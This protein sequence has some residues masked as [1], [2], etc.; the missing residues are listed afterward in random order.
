MPSPMPGDPSAMPPVSS[1]GGDEA[2]GE[3][4]E[5]EDEEGG[6][7]TPPGTICPACGKKDVD[8]KGGE[9]ECHNC[10]AAG[11]ITV[12]MKVTTW[13][14]TIVE[15]APGKKEEG[16]EEGEEGGLGPME[17][18]PGMEMPPAGAPG[19]MPQAGMALSFKVTEEMVKIA[20]GKPVGSWCPHCGSGKVRLAFKTGSGRGECSSCGGKYK[21][22]NFVEKDT[23]QLYASVQW[24]DQR[25]VKLA[26][27]EMAILHDSKRDRL[28]RALKEAKLTDR[29]E[30]SD[31]LEKARIIA[32]LTDKKAL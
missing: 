23:K 3:E 25:V 16:G 14:D 18:G 8:V 10:G 29:F 7:V 19:E 13:P 30:K 24:V 15:K 2:P 6:E 32:L 5:N 27:K 20:G 1:L 26:Q 4:P 28:M 11:T 9:F 31:M 21:I 22:E 12:D 17:G